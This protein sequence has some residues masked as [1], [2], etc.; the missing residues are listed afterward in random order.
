MRLYPFFIP[1]AGCPHRCVFCSQRQSG[2]GAE[3]PSV[4]DVS[5]AL[6]KMLPSRGD[7]EVAFYGGSVAGVRISTRPDA[8]P[9]GMAEGLAAQGVTTVELGCQSFSPLVLR[10]AGRGHDER[11]AADAVGRLRKAG[12]AVGLQLMPGLPGGDR[13]EAMSSL[14]MAL[15]LG[16]DFLRIYPAVVLRH[17][18]LAQRYRTGRYTPLSLNEAVDWCAE[19]LWRCW[20]VDMP[21][22]RLGLQATP[23]LD[24]GDDWLA[25]PYHPAFGQLV[26]SRLWLQTLMGAA[27]LTGARKATVHPADLGDAIGHRRENLR[28]M[29]QNFGEFSLAPHSGLEKG[30]VVLDGQKFSL[31]NFLTYKG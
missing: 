7:G 24:A 12:L 31:T 23:E 3:Q 8:V 17:T 10:L 13:A 11:V 19:M 28:T 6:A 18:E 30:H 4:A 20:Q 25:G 5:A 16:P 9:P 14:T 26:R 27:T 1:H 29:Q 2:G 21:V 15:A 22:I